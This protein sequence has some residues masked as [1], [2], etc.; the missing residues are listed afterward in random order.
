MGF[1]LQRQCSS[2]AERPE[3][4][5]ATKWPTFNAVPFPGVHRNKAVYLVLVFSRQY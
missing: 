2:D 1:E 3:V 5:L 4:D